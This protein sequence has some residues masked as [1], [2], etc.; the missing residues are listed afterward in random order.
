M[1]FINNFSVSFEISGWSYNLSQ[2]TLKLMNEFEK[3]IPSFMENLIADFILFF[4]DIAKF[5]FL[6]GRLGTRICVH[7]I[8]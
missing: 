6:R 8:S 5:L 3:C 7:S 1:V 4:S 2:N